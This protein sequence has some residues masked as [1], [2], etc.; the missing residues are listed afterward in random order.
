M[1]DLAQAINEKTFHLLGL[2][3][4]LDRIAILYTDLDNVYCRLEDAERKKEQKANLDVMRQSYF[5]MAAI[6]QNAEKKQ[7]SN[8]EGNSSGP[9]GH[10]TLLEV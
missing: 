8:I 6:I 7:S 9:L 10:S 5:K 2:R 1:T 4:R 3:L